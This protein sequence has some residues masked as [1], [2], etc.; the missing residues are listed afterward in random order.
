MVEQD[1]SEDWAGAVLGSF[2]RFTRIHHMDG[3]CVVAHTTN[4][5]CD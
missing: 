2:G 3:A 1:A 4:L 5:S